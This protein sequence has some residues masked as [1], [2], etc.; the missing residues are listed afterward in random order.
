MK[1]T[2]AILMALTFVLASF[3][4]LTAMA[5]VKGTVVNITSTTLGESFETDCENLYSSTYIEPDTLNTDYWMV[6]TGIGNSKVNTD[7][8][9]KDGEKVRVENGALVVPASDTTEMGATYNFDAYYKDGTTYTQT[10]RLF[11]FTGSYLEADEYVFEF[12]ADIRYGAKVYLHAAGTPY[13]TIRSDNNSI[14]LETKVNGTKRFDLEKL[15]GMVHNYKIVVRLE[16]KDASGN[17]LTHNKSDGKC[18]LDGV[19]VANSSVSIYVMTDIYVDDVCRVIN[20]EASKL[21]F[22]GR[23]ITQISFLTEKNGLGLTVDNIDMYYI[24]GE[25]RTDAT[26]A[27]KNASDKTVFNGAADVLNA[28][29]NKLEVELR[30]DGTQ[31]AAQAAKVFVALYNVNGKLKNVKIADSTIPANSYNKV[32]VTVNAPYFEDATFENGDYIRVF[33]LETNKIAPFA[34]S[35]TIKAVQ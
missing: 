11:G 28:S 19:L 4:S 3:A 10:R 15:D 7:I 6:V 25:K 29:G 31:T 1:K 32:D 21:S 14:Y 27:F 13:A 33:A 34:P 26:F 20:E 12:D 35:K 8:T 30:A 17:K 9:G 5:T 2:M 22:T 24:N 23:Y 16:Y 18:Y